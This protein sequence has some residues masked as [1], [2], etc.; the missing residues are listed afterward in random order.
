MPVWLAPA[1]VAV[2]GFTVLGVQYATF[3][4][5][6]TKFNQAAASAGFLSHDLNHGL[7]SVNGSVLRAHDAISRH[8]EGSKNRHDI[9]AGIVT[10]AMI[11][12]DDQAETFSTNAEKLKVHAQELLD[13]SEA[14]AITPRQAVS[15]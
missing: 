12:F 11:N 2:F 8:A 7:R 10:T 9:M 4:W 6:K 5:M 15:R 3:R 13:R 1:L 14:H